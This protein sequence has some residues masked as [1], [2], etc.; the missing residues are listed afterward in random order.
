MRPFNT[1]FRRKG[2]DG[3]REDPEHRKGQ[4]EAEAYHAD[5]KSLFLKE[6]SPV[7][8]EEDGQRRQDRE[9]ADDSD[10]KEKAELCRM[11]APCARLPDETHHLQAYDRKHAGHEVEQKSR[12][13]PEE[14]SLDQIT[15]DFTGDIARRERQ[16]SVFFK[17]MAFGSALPVSLG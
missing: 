1:T 8:A 6:L 13:E 9:G 4:G 15:D 5:E 2:G 12:E 16:L 10:G 17:R 7:V 11:G 3:E 14:N